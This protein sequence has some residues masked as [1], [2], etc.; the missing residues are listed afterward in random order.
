MD[1]LPNVLG[2]CGKKMNQCYM[3]WVPDDGSLSQIQLFSIVFEGFDFLSTSRNT[4]LYI[5]R[6]WSLYS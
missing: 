1:I 2:T 6:S 3:I 4:S 5:F